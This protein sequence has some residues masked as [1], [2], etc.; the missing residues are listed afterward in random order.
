M[1][2]GNAPNRSQVRKVA[3]MV[4]ALA[5]LIVTL[6]MSGQLFES[7]DAN[8][9]LVIQ[10]PN[11]KMSVYT[12][13][14]SFHWQGFGKATHYSMRGK[15][16]F[17]EKEEQGG[18]GI[19]AGPIGI[20]FNDA[21]KAMLSG[22]IDYTMPVDEDH[23][24]A[25]HRA[26]STQASLDSDLMR[27]LVEKSVY[28]AGPLMSSRES[29]AER[30]NDLLSLIYDQINE[31]VYETTTRQVQT[32]DA[33]SGQMKTV[34]V[35]EIKL[36]E[37]GRPMRQDESPLKALGIRTYNLSINNV[38]YDE[39]VDKQIA[40]QQALTQQVQTAI[41]EAREAEQRKITTEQQGQADAAKA[42]WEQ[43]VK[44]AQQV[45]EAEQRKAV[46]AL[47]AET[48]EQRRIEQVRLGQGEAERKRLVMEADGALQPKLDALVAI[49]RVWAE[50]LSKANVPGVV[51]CDA[52]GDSRQL[53]EL[54]RIAQMMQIQTAR[55]L[56]VD[57][58]V[59]GQNA[60]KR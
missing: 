18:P 12:T 15:V 26:Y 47:D 16:W 20:Q 59:V 33:I 25:I 23:V 2:E 55:A 19:L 5:L 51:I 41:A 52:G 24:L 40:Q 3:A 34:A 14:S 6:T 13:P 9:I 60:T 49:N 32:E 29:Y 1:Y 7:N 46:A 58:S 39:A 54:D 57:V 48:A 56:G 22:S 10:H 53:G 43:E 4:V 44:K 30:K 21:A 38:D 27:T 42:K 28:L 36:G 11:G 31:G 50:S 17:S 8:Q 45:T 37:D 35:V